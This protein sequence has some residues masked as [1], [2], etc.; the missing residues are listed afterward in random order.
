MNLPQRPGEELPCSLVGPDGA[1]TIVAISSDPALAAAVRQRT[2]REVA[3]VRWAT[4]DALDDVWARTDPWPWVVVGSGLPRPALQR[5]CRD[6]TPV[7][8]WL[9]GDP[10][11]LPP[12]G[13]VLA[14]WPAL[15][16]W[17]DRL[18]QVSAAGLRLSPYR[19]VLTPDGTRR[20]APV[21]EALLAAHPRGLPDSAL[22]RRTVG[23]LRGWGIPCH[24]RR[25]GE[26]LRLAIGSRR[27]RRDTEGGNR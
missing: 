19:G 24:T 26:L 27:K 20:S 10:E 6:A 13:M 1:R 5:H 25:D 15:A 18:H 23:R 8:A 22:V 2:P 7:V 16:R 17:L 4:W 9:G 11:G 12:G 14:G 3:I 21:A